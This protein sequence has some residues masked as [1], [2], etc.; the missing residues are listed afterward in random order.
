[1][2]NKNEGMLLK[3]GYLYNKK[4]RFW[5]NG[6]TAL[7]VCDR[8]SNYMSDEYLANHLNRLDDLAGEKWT[9]NWYTAWRNYTL[10]EYKTL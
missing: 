8:T 4:E 7:M 1:M 5:I 3:C 2:N 6:R 9:D 10:K